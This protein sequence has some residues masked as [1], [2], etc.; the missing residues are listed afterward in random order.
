MLVIT[1]SVIF[2]LLRFVEIWRYSLFWLHQAKV[3]I[4]LLSVFYKWSYF[5]HIEVQVSVFLSNKWYK[6]RMWA[7]AQRDGR[8]SEYRWCPL[9]N[10][11]K[12]GWKF[13]GVPQTPEPISAVSG[14]KFTILWG[15]VEEVLLFNR[16]FRFSISARQ[17]CTMVPRWRFFASCISSEPHA[18]HFRP[19]F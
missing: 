3:F 6:T 15:H 16:F 18:A 1:F 14:P 10:A 12:F 17:S 13:V 11:E 8:P 7:N 2:W 4:L 9:F 5:T 19:A